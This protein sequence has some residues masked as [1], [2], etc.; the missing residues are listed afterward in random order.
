MLCAGGYDQWLALAQQHDKLTKAR[1]NV[2]CDAMTFQQRTAQM[3]HIRCVTHDMRTLSFILRAEG[4]NRDAG[5]AIAAALERSK[6]FCMTVPTELEDYLEEVELSLKAVVSCPTIPLEEKVTWLREIRHAHGRTALV[7]SGGGTF[8][9]YHFGI[10]R[11]LL[12]ENM[13]PRI[14]SGSSAGSFAGALIC[15]RTDAELTELAV[16]FPST[17]G[18]D[19]MSHST[20]ADIVRNI[21]AKGSAHD[22]SWYVTRL[23]RLLGRDMT[24]ADAYMRSGRVL[25]IAVTSVDYKEPPRLL[26]YLTA[27]NVL[28]WSAVAC[29]SAFPFLFAPQ[30]LLAKSSDGRV[31]KFTATGPS[32][33]RWADGSLEE[34]L[35]MRG[36]GEMFG[37]NFYIVSQ[38]NPYLLPVLALKKWLPFNLGSYIEDEFKHRV[39]QLLT[40]WP[41]NKVFK[42]M[43]QPWEG[44]VNLLLP[45]TAFPLLKAAVNFSP[46]DIQDAIVIGQDAVFSR[47]AAIRAASRKEACIDECLRMLTHTARLK[48]MAEVRK[49]RREEKPLPKALRPSL[50]SWVHFGTYLATSPSSSSELGE[51]GGESMTTNEDSQLDTF[52]PNK[53]ARDQMW[54]EVAQLTLAAG[55]PG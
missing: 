46:P 1:C 18:L 34:D 25:T 33:R 55:K 3:R 45:M 39:K 28:I 50:P 29:S 30:D 54:Q 11:T 22:S 53:E 36:L 26:N 31:V 38:A 20:T 48:K 19:F 47:L 12:H 27:P 40:L 51:M 10:I 41:R 24:F 42:F 9:F 32:Q 7:L 44:D 43:S 2:E 23:Q 14:I 52:G 37:V 49:A 6:C 15:T 8:G 17:P 35:P 16:D 4:S 21:V 13:L 5:R